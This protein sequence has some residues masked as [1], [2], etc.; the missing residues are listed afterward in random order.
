M[1]SF[2]SIIRTSGQRPPAT[3]VQGRL[4]S[5][6]PFWNLFEVTQAVL[7]AWSVLQDAE[8]RRAYDA[9]YEEKRGQQIAEV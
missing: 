3:P 9:H 7:D 5:S 6:V 4:G 2:A 1:R 8:K